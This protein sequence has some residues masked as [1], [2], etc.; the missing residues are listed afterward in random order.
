MDIFIFGNAAYSIPVFRV[1]ST[2]SHN[3]PRFPTIINHPSFMHYTTAFT[4]GASAS[5]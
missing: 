2:A 1:I 5:W 4:W 3:A